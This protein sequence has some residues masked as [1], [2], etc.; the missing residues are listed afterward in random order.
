[1]NLAKAIENLVDN[2]GY[3]HFSEIGEFQD[4]SELFYECNISLSKGDQVSV[5]VKYEDNSEY[6]NTFEYENNVDDLIDNIT[7]WMQCTDDVY[8]YPAN[9]RFDM[10]F[11]DCEYEQ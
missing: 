2:G 5:E 3:I 8:Q 7:D 4:G 11:I 6:S 1:M 9:I 10:D